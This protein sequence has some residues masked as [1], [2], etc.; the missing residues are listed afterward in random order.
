MIDLTPLDVR[1]K[2]GDF[3]RAMRGYEPALVDDFLDLVAE[4]LEELVRENLGL[5]ERGQQINDS[6]D[7]YRTR[8]TALNEALVSAQQLREE[9]RTQAAREA[10]L[11]LREARAEGERLIGEARK[12]AA[13]TAEAGRRLVGQRVRYMRSFRA[14]VEQQLGELE[15]EEERIREQQRSGPAEQ[16]AAAS[17][18]G[19]ED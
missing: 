13:A 17:D 5:R 12:E 6:L 4:R 10:E 9:V 11:V 7:A 2:K 1:K 15:L 18:A 14:F 8:E 19:G 3:R 16:E